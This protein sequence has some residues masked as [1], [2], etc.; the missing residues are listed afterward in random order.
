MDK[1]FDETKKDIVIKR[2]DRFDTNLR[3]YRRKLAIQ[4]HSIESEDSRFKIAFNK[5]TENEIYSI[6]DKREL[7]YYEKDEEL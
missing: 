7:A 6:D 3:P 4:K 5:P 2:R 1:F